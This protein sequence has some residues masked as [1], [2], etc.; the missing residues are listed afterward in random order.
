MTPAI[1]REDGWAE[2]KAGVQN[3]KGTA[4]QNSWSYF[5]IEPHRYSH[6]EAFYVQL[7]ILLL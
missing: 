7:E 4:K 5:A 3:A 2:K 6:K 1:Y